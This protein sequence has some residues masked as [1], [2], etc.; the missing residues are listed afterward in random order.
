MLPLATP[1]G[2]ELLVFLVIL[3]IPL[4]LA[5]RALK[6]VKLNVESATGVRED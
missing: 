4:Y 2:M 5:Y 6:W 1:G 3:L